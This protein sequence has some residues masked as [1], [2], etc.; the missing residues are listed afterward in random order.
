MQI[1]HGR[2]YSH[3]IPLTRLKCVS[4]K[5]VKELNLYLGLGG[6]ARRRGEETGRAPRVKSD[7]HD[8]PHPLFRSGA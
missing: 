6:A 1:R 4:E 8:R 7:G 3:R 5:R 2:A